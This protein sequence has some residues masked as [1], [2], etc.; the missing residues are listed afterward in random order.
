MSQTQHT[1]PGSPK[2]DATPAPAP[3]RLVRMVIRVPESL[4]W[5][6]RG[7]ASGKRMPVERVVAAV[8]EEFVERERK[9][10]A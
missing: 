8:L 10:A 9:G 7:I 1:A 4:K 6:M 2:Q 5:T 3:D